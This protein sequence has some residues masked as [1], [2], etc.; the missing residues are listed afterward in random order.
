M[1][2]RCAV[3]RYSSRAATNSQKSLPQYIS[4]TKSLYRGLFRNDCLP[5]SAGL[6]LMLCLCLPRAAPAT[7][8]PSSLSNSASVSRPPSDS[9]NSRR[10]VTYYMHYAKTL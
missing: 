3:A 4:Y 5:A 9:R 8:L 6:S 1:C 7:A 2:R 10:S